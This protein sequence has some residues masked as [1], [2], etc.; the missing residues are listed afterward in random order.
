MGACQDSKKIW[1]VVS[2]TS[3]WVIAWGLIKW[4]QCSGCRFPSTCKSGGLEDI[5]LGTVQHRRLRL[6]WQGEGNGAYFERKTVTAF[7]IMRDGIGRWFPNPWRI[8]DKHLSTLGS[9]YSFIQISSYSHWHIAAEDQSSITFPKQCCSPN[10]HF[11]ILQ[12]LHVS[13]NMGKQLRNSHEQKLQ[14]FGRPPAFPLPFLL[15]CWTPFGSSILTPSCVPLGHRHHFRGRTIWEART[16]KS[17]LTAQLPAQF[18]GCKCLTWLE[19]GFTAP[20]VDSAATQSLST[21]VCCS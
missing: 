3:R 2:A 21:F 11:P 14:E 18:W 20:R 12:N 13:R 17:L 8:H 16:L 15:H 6:G 4:I 7:V 10:Q 9:N 19:L 5:E 1:A